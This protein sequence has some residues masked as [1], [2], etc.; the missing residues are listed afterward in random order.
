MQYDA[1]RMLG[2]ANVCQRLIMT[3]KTR[4]RR[5]RLKVFA[6]RPRR[7]KASLPRASY[8]IDHPV[9]DRLCFAERRLNELRVLNSGDLSGAVPRERQSL[10]QEFFFHLCGAIDFLAQ[11]VNEARQLGIPEDI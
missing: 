10:I 1:K 4:A 9:H 2:D 8:Y 11:T 5:M 3:L 6:K 7:G